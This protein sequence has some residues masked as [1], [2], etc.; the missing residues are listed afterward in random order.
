MCWVVVVM[1]VK[2]TLHCG[3]VDVGGSRARGADGGGGGDG[4]GDAKLLVSSVCGW[5]GW[6]DARSR[7]GNKATP[8]Q[9]GRN[10]KES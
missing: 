5:A 6:A 4:G 1:M 10:E 3:S 7:S 8:E 2:Q 9:R